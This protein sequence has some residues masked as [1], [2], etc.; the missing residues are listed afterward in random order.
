LIRRG[1]EWEGAVLGVLEGRRAARI[2]FEASR[3]IVLSWIPMGARGL[4]CR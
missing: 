4:G 2:V 3:Q 1:L